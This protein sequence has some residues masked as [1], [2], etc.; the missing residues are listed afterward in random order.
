[1]SQT[2]LLSLLVHLILVNH[3]RNKTVKTE[4]YRYLNMLT[5]GNVG[6]IER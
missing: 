4:S 5:S 6:D 1:M 2:E 3:K